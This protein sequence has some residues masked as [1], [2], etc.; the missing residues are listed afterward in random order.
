MKIRLQNSNSYLSNAHSANMKLQIRQS[1][2]ASNRAVKLELDMKSNRIHAIWTPFLTVDGRQGNEKVL[3]S[4]IEFEKVFCANCGKKANENFINCEICG[5]NDYIESNKFDLVC[6]N[7]TCGLPFYIKGKT[8]LTIGKKPTVSGLRFESKLVAGQLIFRQVQSGRVSNFDTSK[9]IELAENI[10][11]GEFETCGCFAERKSEIAFEKKCLRDSEKAKIKNHYSPAF[12]P[13]LIQSEIESKM[14]RLK[15]I[16]LLLS[17][18]SL[19]RKVAKPLRNEAFFLCKNLGINDFDKFSRLIV[20]GKIVENGKVKLAPVPAPIS[21]MVFVA[22]SA[23]KQASGADVRVPSKG[24][25]S[26]GYDIREKAVRRH[27]KPLPHLKVKRRE[28]NV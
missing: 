18:S 15:E 27:V 5:L 11:D 2:G 23:T 17:D 20:S 22:N 3:D 12:L 9:Q 7:E 19:S 4:I 16:A 6:P 1:G 13:A 8:P 25:N 26:E 10:R 24:H 21:N 28:E 14:I